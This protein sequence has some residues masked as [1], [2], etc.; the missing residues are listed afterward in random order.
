[1]PRFLRR[2]RTANVF[3]AY[4]KPHQRI[5]WRGALHRVLTRLG[6]TWRSA[7]VR[8]LVQSA[9]LVLFLYAFFHV[10]WPYSSPFSSTTLSDKEW[11]PAEGFLWM[12]PLSGISTALAG[13]TLHWPTLRWTAG[14]LLFC[15]LVPR[16]FCGHLCPLGTLIDL[17][18]WLVG[19]RFRRLHL[20]PR[21]PTRATAW[22]VH[23]KYY[24][25]VVVLAA[26]LF[27]VLLAGFVSAI[28]VLTRALLFSGGRL[29]V[30]VM[31]GASHLLPVDWTFHLSMVL[32]AGIFLAGLLGKR[33]WCR[34]LCPT[35]ALF[36]V[37]H[38]FRVGQRT[39]TERCTGCGKCVDVC[40]FDAV[41][42]DF[43]TRAGDCAW[44]Q[45][46]GG[47]CPAQ[48]V[49]FVTRWNKPPRAD[50]E[51][52]G[53]L[54]GIGTGSRPRERAPVRRPPLSRRGFVAASL[55]GIAAGA[56]RLTG[57]HGPI[58]EGP[59]PIRPPGSVG[60]EEFLGLC[61]RCGECFK[62]CPGPVLHPA[63]L[64]YGFESLW[65]PVARLEHAGCHQDCNFCTQVCPTGAISPLD[66]AVKRRTRMGLARIDSAAC[67]PHRKDQLRQDCDL[68]Y[69]ECRRAGYDAI[70]MREIRIELTP[71]PPEGMFSEMELEAMS[72]IRIP[73]VKAEACVGCGI[74]QYRCHTRYVIQEQS[75]PTSAIVVTPET[76]CPPAE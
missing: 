20:G 14:I 40:P 41:G 27:G 8:R 57:R 55:F 26:A 62:V 52:P 71:P 19:R 65:T 25:L 15:L 10:C 60:E 23:I 32:F 38:V 1:M 24:L 36:S 22:W 61:I 69:V 45:S 66:I 34:Y 21:D 5:G 17:F 6:P 59:R 18:D 50:A 35:G 74:C 76:E 9:C 30:A 47:V 68:C 70:E 12:D 28:P 37:L 39:V 11:F 75:L 43:T 53:R 56:T 51:A 46:C 54:E 73:V 58:A 42:E 31:K 29:Q 13:R 2:P 44:C 67:L 48:A 3:F 7:P 63:G 16:A 49:Q 64:E 33:F 72:R 4:L